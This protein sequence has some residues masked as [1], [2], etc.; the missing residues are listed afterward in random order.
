M[1]NNSLGTNTM[2]R[3]YIDDD[4]SKSYTHK[5]LQSLLVSELNLYD[6]RAN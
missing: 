3:E 5:E 6:Y 1:E 4:F 2:I